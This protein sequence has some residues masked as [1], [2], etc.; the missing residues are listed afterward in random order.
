M[1]NKGIIQS[2]AAWMVKSKVA[3]NLLMFVFLIGGFYMF[4]QTRQEFLPDVRLGVVNI[5]VTYDAATPDEIEKS[6]VLAIEE[7][8]RDIDGIEKMSSS[9]QEGSGSISL[10]LFKGVNKYQVY[11]DVKSAVDSLT[12]LPKQAEIPVVSLESDKRDVMEIMFYGD[13]DELSLQNYIQEVKQQLLNKESISLIELETYNE[14]EMSIQISE[15]NLRKYNLTLQ[16]VADI[17]AQ[18]SLE[19]GAG[20][21]YTKNQD[22]LLKVDERKE[23]VADIAMLPILTTENSVIIR[24]QDIA[25]IKDGFRDKTFDLKFNGQNGSIVTIYAVGGQSPIAVQDDVYDYLNSIKLPENLHYEIIDNDANYFLQRADILLKNAIAGLILIMIILGLFLDPRLAFWVMLGL[26]ISII[27]SFLFIPASD[28]TINMISMMAFIIT[29]GVVVDDAII[30]GENIYD[31]LDE[32]KSAIQAAITGVQ[33]MVP[34]VVFAVLTNIVAFLPMLFIGGE[35]GMFFRPI[36]VVLISVLAVSLI[37]SLFILPSHLSHT[38]K[39][40]TSEIIHKLNVP[41]LYINKKLEEF[42]E[43]KF[44]KFVTLAISQRYT[45]LAIAI[46]MLIMSVGLINGGFVK[47]SP[48]PSIEADS[49]QAGGEFAFGNSEVD[50]QNA[51]KTLHSSLNKTIEHFNLNVDDISYETIVGEKKLADETTPDGMHK[52][53]FRAILPEVR[54]FTATDFA[55]TWKTNTGRIEGASSLVFSGNQ[56][57][58]GSIRIELSALNKNTLDSASKYLLEKVS[59]LDGVDLAQST[60]QLGKLQFNFKLTEKAK[61]IGITADYLAQEIRNTYFGAEAFAQQVDYDEVTYRVKL[62]ESERYSLDKL[63]NLRIILPN[64]QEAFLQDLADIQVV[65]SASSIEKTNGNR[66]TAILISLN[67]EVDENIF[68]ANL[69]EKYLNTLSAK[70]PGVEYSFEGA[71][72]DDE[73]SLEDM[74]Y[75][76]VIAIIVIYLLLVLLFN[77]YIEPFIIITSIP[78]GAVGAILGHLLMQSNF[79]LQSM[80]GLLALAGIV[81][82]NGLVLVITINGYLKQSLSVDESLIIAAKRRLRPILLT[83]L[84]TFIGLVPILTETSHQA[85]FLIPMVISIAF[86]L[87][88]STLVTLALVPS[89]FKIFEDFGFKNK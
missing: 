25:E 54:T 57:F 43:T 60:D 69:T 45:V 44:T 40:E 48:R 62:K 61:K 52:F 56:N 58:A 64:K 17:I 75:G 65:R 46:G 63:H 81:V 4:T 59:Y 20:T 27:G 78:F 10:E 34:S 3:A 28:V 36:P 13:L 51:I 9:S 21:L 2:A 85:A 74:E 53:S 32:Y 70:F 15:D 24:L 42:T 8:V 87:L 18:N 89:M 72:D 66:V 88:Y 84:T 22:I 82:N 71:K 23:S 26:P 1:L 5:D 12:T 50:S 38:P 86:G 35:M 29:L 11:Q 31:K 41:R 39:K 33:E 67:K 73:G 14:R 16:E 37:E 30:V 83:S 6:V 49:V 68:N 19:K 47:L 7:A 55:E 80:I 76:F 77:N 79:T